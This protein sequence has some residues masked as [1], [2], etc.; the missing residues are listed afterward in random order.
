MQVRLLHES[1]L[2]IAKELLHQLGYDDISPSELAARI[3]RVLATRTHYTAVADNGGTVLGLIHAYERPALEKPH[4]AIVQ[5]LV[6]D[7]SAR[8]SGTGKLL[9]TAAE[10]WARAGGLKH[11]ALHTRIDRADARAFYEQL[12]YHRAATAHLMRKSLATT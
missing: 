6:V 12:G 5:S 10:A 3:D 4:E 2:H 9:M 1:D 7:A 11:I 8:K